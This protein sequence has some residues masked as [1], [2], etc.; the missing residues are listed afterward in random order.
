MNLST[1]K[2]SSGVVLT[3][4][5]PN[6]CSIKPVIILCNG[7]CGIREMSVPDFARRFTNAGFSTITFDYRGFGDSTGEKGRLIPS[8]QIE[9]ILS[10]ITWAKGQPGL[11]PTRIGLWGTSIGGC[12]VFGAAARDSGINCIVSQ[13]AFAD[14]EEIIARRMCDSSKK[15]LISVLD[16]MAKKKEETGQ[17]IY[18]CLT[19]ILC[20]EDSKEFFIKNNRI[21]KKMDTII[22]L[23]TVRETLLYK[24]EIYASQV[25][26]PTLIVTAENDMVNPPGQGR[27]LFESVGSEEKLLHEE[28]KARHYDL[29]S[30][31][32]FK[33]IILLQIGWFKQYL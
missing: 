17:E 33:R 3:L 26:C 28:K 2:L 16:K 19:K 21:H 5:T 1:Y 4:R 11:D 31:I 24:P 13:L 7:F 32:H 6:G 18:V 23:L 8:M 20:D 9:D 12:H 27:A 14:G 25:K 10:V 30:G 22:P 15:A 29:Y